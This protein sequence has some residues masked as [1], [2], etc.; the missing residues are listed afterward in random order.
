MSV[1]FDNVS[2]RELQRQRLVK[3]VSERQSGDQGQTAKAGRPEDLRDPAGQE[4]VRQ[5]DDEDVPSERTW[6][7]EY[8]DD[9]DDGLAA[10]PADVREAALAPEWTGEGEAWAAGFLH[11]EPGPSGR[12]FAAGGI[13]DRAAAGPALAAL[14]ASVTEPQAG[15]HA[16]LGESELIGVM[17]AWR[18]MA[19]W[20][21]AGEAAAVIALDRRRNAQ[22]RELDNPHLAEHVTEEIAAALTLTG[23][24]AANLRADALGL[25]R[26]PAVHEQ[27]ATGRIDQAKA[28]VFTGELAVLPGPAAT[29]IAAQVLPEAP[30]LTTGQLRA[31][32]RRLIL[33]HDP[34]A[35]SRR[36]REAARDAE[37]SV[38]TEA[39]G[40]AAL[41]GRELP[42][43]DVLAADK[44]LTALAR[45]LADRGAEGTLSQLRAAVFTRLLTGRAIQSLLPALMPATAGPG[46]PEDV[47]AVTG[48][49]N[50]TM[51]LSAL[52]DTS[53]AIG[54]IAGYGP[55]SADTCRDLVT[56]MTNPGRTVSQA[57]EPQWCLT[58]TD[59]AG[60]AIGHACA[61]RGPGPPRGRA[62]IV[63]AAALLPWTSRLEAGACT[64]RR[65]EDH[66]RPSARLAHLI[67]VRQPECTGP[68]CRRPAHQCDLDHTVAYARGGRTCECGLAPACRTHHRAKQAPGWHLSQP[69]PGV[70]IWTLP[71]R[72]SYRIEP[73]RYP[74]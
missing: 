43:A 46:D 25:A 64:H 1:A 40:N 31:M 44:R 28:T 19:A 68:G 59:D 73:Y 62:A 58:V 11:H 26:L 38:W 48:S 60:H 10:L 15:G 3:Q 53:Q 13:A 8:D 49:I 7:P 42:E 71:H 29:V 35:A 2:D 17:C 39:S 6:D 27:L 51:P 41:A 12:G 9:P 54:E 34:D 67:K 63:W 50:L 52:A 72:R 36:K 56:F 18:R 74:V 23:R 20:A 16:E 37:V 24:S 70:M 5:Y 45:W 21:A 4:W 14:I 57:P 69:E 66:Y 65:E 32:L 61:G 47:P 22:S 30:A 33:A 55:A